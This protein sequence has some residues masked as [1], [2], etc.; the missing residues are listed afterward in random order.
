MCRRQASIGNQRSN[1]L[2]KKL[3]SKEN[4]LMQL[5][6]KFAQSEAKV[7]S[8]QDRIRGYI[9][10]F[11][12]SD[13]CERSKLQISLWCWRLTDAEDVHE[14]E[15]GGLKQLIDKLQKQ[16]GRVTMNDNRTAWISGQPAC[17]KGDNLSNRTKVMEALE[18]CK[19]LKS[20]C[21]FNHKGRCTLEHLMSRLKVKSRWQGPYCSHLD[22]DFN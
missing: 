7:H 12:K 1:S 19:T 8:L 22:A 15:R 4:E 14:N 3:S 21:G 10:Y 18:L 11:R 5:Q 13:L 2:Q 9:C 16:L 17:L 20:C 6:L